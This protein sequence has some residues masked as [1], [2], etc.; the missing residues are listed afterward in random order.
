MFLHFSNDEQMNFQ[1]N[2][3]LMSVL[4]EPA[5]PPQT[6]E[7]ARTLAD[8]NARTL[9]EIT[10][11]ASKITDMASWSA[12]WWAAAEKARTEQRFKH[13]A[14]YYR[15]TWHIGKIPWRGSKF[16]IRIH[17]CLQSA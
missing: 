9:A 14:A 5:L 7:N 2:R 4:S 17:I 3:A 12:T 15:M 10:A 6:D 11:A 8:Q 16:P 1:I 13:A